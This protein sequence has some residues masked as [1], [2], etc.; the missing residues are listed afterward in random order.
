MQTTTILTNSINQILTENQSF[1]FQGNSSHTPLIQHKTKIS[2]KK[3][4]T[5]DYLEEKE[6]RETIKNIKAKIENNKFKYMR[7]KNKVLSTLSNKEGLVVKNILKKL[8]NCP[9][10]SLIDKYSLTRAVESL[11]FNCL[12]GTKGMHKKTIRDKSMDII[13]GKCNCSE[14]VTKNTPRK[15]NGSKNNEITLE[16]ISEKIVQSLLE[17]GLCTINNKEDAFN[18]INENIDTQTVS[19]Y[20]EKYGSFNPIIYARPFKATG[21]PYVGQTFRDVRGEGEEH[22]KELKKGRHHN[23]ALQKDFNKYGAHNFGQCFILEKIDCKMTDKIKDIK[24]KL[25][26]RETYY[27]NFLENSF[28]RKTYNN[29][30]KKARQN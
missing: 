6:E 10:K 28:G 2:S 29:I 30:Q 25:L 20:I 17:Q 11:N 1:L 4:I 8:I 5:E 18:I 14:C 21:I 13:L 24:K 12:K 7:N 22:L 15:T 27:I 16:K 23:K 3:I 19:T 26:E 9:D